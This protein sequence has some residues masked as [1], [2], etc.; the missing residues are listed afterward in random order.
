VVEPRNESALGKTAFGITGDN[1]L[2]ALGGLNNLVVDRATFGTMPQVALS[3]MASVGLR[4]GS[5][6]HGGASAAVM[7]DGTRA[8]YL[9]LAAA[10]GG[11]ASI[12]AAVVGARNPAGPRPAEGGVTLQSITDMRTTIDALSGGN[13]ADPLNPDR[14]IATNGLIAAESQSMTGMSQN[15]LSLKSMKEGFAASVETLRKPIQQFDFNAMALAYNPQAGAAPATAVN[16]FTQQ[17]L[18]AELM[19]RS[20]TNVVF[21]GDNGWDSHGD[22]T[23]T[24]VRQMMNTRILAGLNTFLARTQAPDFGVNVVVAIVGDFS[25]SLPGS[26][27]QNSLTATVIGKYVKVGTTGKVR[28]TGATPQA[29]RMVLDAPAAGAEFWSFLASAVKAPT[30]PFGAAPTHAALLT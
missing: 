14:G 5:S 17:M 16:N 9:Q 23:A 10:M 8:R 13:R 19:I 21:A 26:D 28:V 15:P 27:H 1:Q 30:N 7:S 11:E 12:K 4:H 18:A 20:G 2:Q 24:R 3:R 6:D 25:R 29:A 22:T